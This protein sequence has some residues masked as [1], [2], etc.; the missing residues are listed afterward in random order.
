[1][2]V[3]KSPEDM[4]V[5]RLRAEGLINPANGRRTG[6]RP[7][8]IAVVILAAFGLG[9]LWPPII[10]SPAYATPRYVLL[11]YEGPAYRPGSGRA[12]EYRDWARRAHDGGRVVGGEELTTTH[13][14]L[15]PARFDSGQPA[16][17]FVVEARDAA[18][19]VRLA[20]SCPHLRHGGSIAVRSVE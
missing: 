7:I 18:S 19:A 3:T 8:L 11:L 1:M 2:I 10:G 17:M 4:L 9:T 16:G 20:R 15:G 14:W 5:D 6:M 13:A 12:L